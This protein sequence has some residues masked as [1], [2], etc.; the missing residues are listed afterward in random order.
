MRNEKITKKEKSM[1]KTKTAKRK[2]SKETYPG[3]VVLILAYTLLC[4]TNTKTT[5]TI[6][7]KAL[8]YINTNMYIYGVTCLNYM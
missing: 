3:G 2:P 7:N 8:N 4:Q 1:T 6:G 5:Q